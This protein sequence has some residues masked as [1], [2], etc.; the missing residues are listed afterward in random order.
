METEIVFTTVARR[1]HHKCR[2]SSHMSP[3]PTLIP[4]KVTMKRGKEGGGRGGRKVCPKR[5]VVYIK[6]ESMFILSSLIY[7]K[8]RG[9][10]ISLE[11]IYKENVVLR[12]C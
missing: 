9:K 12:H 8:R 10:S 11:N 1:E 3:I 7:C 5:S 6:P 2:A 4:G